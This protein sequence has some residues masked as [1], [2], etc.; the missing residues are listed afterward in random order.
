MADERVQKVT[1]SHPSLGSLL[2]RRIRSSVL[3]FRSV[4]FA[5]IPGRFRQSVL[6]KDL[7]DERDFTEY[8]FACPARHQDA[9]W[10]GGPLPWETPRKYDE[11][12]C[13]NL[14]IST[15]ITSMI[16]EDSRE[17]SLR[18][19][20]LVYCHGG[21][22]V[23]GAGNISDRQGEIYQKFWVYIILTSPILDTSNMVEISSNAGRPVVT[24]NIQ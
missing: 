1:V 14:T 16:R 19:P 4:P 11:F 17:L 13:L 2:G 24:V 21:G 15:P 5:T 3:Q 23:E 18:L 7:G 10:N 20:V 8:G 12:K 9:D 6:V 22:F